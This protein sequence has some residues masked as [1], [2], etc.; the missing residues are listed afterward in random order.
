MLVGGGWPSATWRR[1]V[2]TI[3]LAER[4]GRSSCCCCCC[5]GGG[6]RDVSGGRGG[7]LD[8]RS[9]RD[10]PRRRGSD[11]GGGRTHGSHAHAA[12]AVVRQRRVGRRHVRVEYV[13]Q[14]VGWAGTGD[15][16]AP[17]HPWRQRW[18]VLRALLLQRLLHVLLQ[19][20]R[21]N[22]HL[23]TKNTPIHCNSIKSKIK[24]YN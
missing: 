5:C 7:H 15:V 19:G 21:R 9:G 3:A 6:S 8:E 23:A 16:T 14:E 12:L 10:Q 22:V 18:G 13:R 11:A 24:L 4:Q 20:L 17:R 2:K 1:Q